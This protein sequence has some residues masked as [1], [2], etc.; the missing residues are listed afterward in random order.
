MENYENKSRIPKAAW[1]VGGLL[2]LMLMFWAVFH[3]FNM[4]PGGNNNNVIH[5]QENRDE[6]VMVND[7]EKDEVLGWYETTINKLESRV[8][9][10]EKHAIEKADN[11]VQAQLVELETELDTLR[12]HYKQVKQATQGEWMELKSRFE[13]TRMQ[14]E[15]KLQNDYRNYS[16]SK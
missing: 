12:S 2:A 6:S 15:E 5:P 9:Q 3:V 10:M 1:I 4:G 7:P 16:V 14:V 8:D 13:M 11:S